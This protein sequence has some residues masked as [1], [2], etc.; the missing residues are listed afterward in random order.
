MSKMYDTNL[1]GL[2]RDQ[3]VLQVGAFV[4]LSMVLIV[5]VISSHPTT[6]TTQPEPG[7]NTTVQSGTN[8][9]HHNQHTTSPHSLREPQR[10]DP[11]I[12]A[13]FFVFVACVVVMAILSVP[14]S[15]QAH[16]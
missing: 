8:L 4:A 5:A 3:R 1:H 16:S 11:V 14:I 15:F 9:R 12:W 2:R 6:N 10:V 13:D 7:R